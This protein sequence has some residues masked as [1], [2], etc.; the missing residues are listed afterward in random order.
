MSPGPWLGVALGVA[1]EEGL[2]SARA[3]SESPSPGPFFLHTPSHFGAGKGVWRPL[4][5][6]WRTI[7]R[8]E[9]GNPRVESR[10]GGRDILKSKAGNAGKRVLGPV[11]SVLIHPQH[12]QLDRKSV[13]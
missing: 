7:T 9:G 1:E 8:E 4:L 12:F 11:F 13:V 2:G 10:E 3:G 5:G 6:K